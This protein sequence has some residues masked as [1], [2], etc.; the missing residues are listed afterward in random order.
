MA[1]GWE[2]RKRAEEELEEEEEMEKGPTKKD[3]MAEPK[4]ITR[5]TITQRQRARKMRAGL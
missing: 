2:K 4:T 3:L 5:G 1:K